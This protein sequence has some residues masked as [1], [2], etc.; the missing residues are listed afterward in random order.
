MN[1]Y[2]WQCICTILLGYCVGYL[3]T[4]PDRH[5]QRTNELSNTSPTSK[6]RSHPVTVSSEP[7]RLST[8]NLAALMNMDYRRLWFDN[9]DR[10]LSQMS[11]SSL[12]NLLLTADNQYDISSP[13][14]LVT[15]NLQSKIV[16]EIHQ[17]EGKAILDWVELPALHPQVTLE[18]LRLIAIDEP[19][20]FILPMEK[21]F[22]AQVE[23]YRKRHPQRYVYSNP[24]FQQMF[25]DIAI[26]SAFQQDL[27]A[28][29]QIPK[30][31]LRTVSLGSF[32]SLFDHSRFVEQVGLEEIAKSS[33]ARD[34]FD[35]WALQY[36]EV[37]WKAA[38]QIES[39][40]V[41]PV[42]AK[43]ITET[44]FRSVSRIKGDAA[45]EQWRNQLA[46]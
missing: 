13:E 18:F 25:S 39:A 40:S 37:A 3:I 30:E 34:F 15:T 16:R 2:R 36:P 43:N 4:N 19:P 31:T 23:Q 20:R 27:D 28:V 8:H 33:Y 6:A 42:Q 21:K 7:Y 26:K 5:A 9:V 17:R 46:E 12:K 38:Q 14:K 41:V 10:Q 22:L 35:T 45:A 44:V 1:S 24:T 29:L 32:P 11:T